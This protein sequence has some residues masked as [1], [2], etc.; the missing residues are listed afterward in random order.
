[1]LKFA[2]FSFSLFV[3]NILSF[4]FGSRGEETMTANKRVV[5]V[6]G[7]VGG[8]AVAKQLEDVADVTLIE[9]KDFHEVPYAGLRCIVEPTFTGRSLIKLSEILKQAR[10]VQSAAESVSGSE[11]IT[12]AGDHVPFDFLVLA[13]GT[14]FSGPRTKDERVKEYEAEA[15][16]LKAANSVLI[17][18]GGPVAVELAGE[19]AID[20]PEKK[21]TIVHSGDRLIQFLGNKASQK[22]LKWLQAKKV[23]V[24]LNDRIE[25][26]DLAPPNYV[27]KNGTRITADA[28]FVCIGKRVGSSWLQNSDLSDSLDHDGHLKVDANLRLE[29]KSNIFVVGDITNTKEI[30][31][32]FLASKQAAVVVK[33]IKKLSKAT[34]TAK[35]SE[36]AVYK[37]L[38]SPFGIV[39][40]GRYEG[41]AQLPIMT[42]IGRLPGMLKS[43]DLFVGKARAELG[44]PK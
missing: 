24:I 4:F 37:P 44:V 1:M 3:S 18:G 26:E 38:T 6:G 5:V 12:A 23:E 9:P 17:V 25:I 14:T 19:I 43:K 41:V 2:N 30:K 27:T 39:S 22:T 42:I 21:V 16:K 34:E 32:G 7:G 8:A 13:T 28:H 36:L 33:N 35:A 20:F 15:D 10:V 31:Q 11:V 29:G 40:L